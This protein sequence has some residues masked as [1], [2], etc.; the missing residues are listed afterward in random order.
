MKENVVMIFF[1][2]IAVVSV[3]DLGFLRSHVIETGARC[4]AKFE[5]VTN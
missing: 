2:V 1:H 5:T 4:A 3:S